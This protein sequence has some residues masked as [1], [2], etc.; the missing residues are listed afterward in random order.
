M[1]NWDFSHVF[2]PSLGFNFN[3]VGTPR[4][5]SGRLDV[6]LVPASTEFQSPWWMQIRS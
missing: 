4:S 3:R 1:V 6:D 2:P 5:I